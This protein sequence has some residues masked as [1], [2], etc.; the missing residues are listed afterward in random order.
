MPR[1]TTKDQ[2]L[3]EI[4]D[5]RG[6]LEALLAT[7]PADVFAKKEVIGEWTTKDVLSHLIAWE[8]MV[9]LWV[10]SGIE[11]KTIPIPAEGF[12]WSDLPALNE[13]IFRAHQ[14]DTVEDVQKK[15]QE[16]YI[17]ILELLNSLSEKDLFTPG[18]Y[19]WQNKNM[20][21]AYFK[22]CMSSHYLW[23]RKEISKGLKG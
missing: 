16:S 11:G 18:L 21:S 8:Q 4:V 1:P 19:K 9:I 15:F 12:K 5:E 17:Q 3:K 22:S 23:A 2:L 14:K 13:S 7:I 6:K 20:L 10:T